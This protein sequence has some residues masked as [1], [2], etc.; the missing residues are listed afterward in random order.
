MPRIILKKIIELQNVLFDLSKWI[1]ADRKQ[2]EKAHYEIERQVQLC[3]DLCISIAKRIISSE[4]K[5]VPET[6]AE[7]FE[8]LYKL[9][10][11]PKGLSEKM[12][13]AVGLRNIIIHE[14]EDLDYDLFF[15]GLGEG[16]RSFRSFERVILKKLKF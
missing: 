16:Y 9:K 7:A 15:D 10:W 1:G 3:V 4:G 5:R 12:K 6:F 13:R 14:Y 2:Q 8:I 11:V